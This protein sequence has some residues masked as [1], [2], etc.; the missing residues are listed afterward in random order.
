MTWENRLVVLAVA[1]AVNAVAFTVLDHAMTE[2]AAMDRLLQLEPPRV[3]VTARKPGV[4]PGTVVASRACPD[5]MT[6]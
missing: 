5:T 2:G 4:A 1:V 3:T 6:P